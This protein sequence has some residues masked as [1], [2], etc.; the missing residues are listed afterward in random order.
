MNGESCLPQLFDWEEVS[1]KFGCD[2]SLPAFEARTSLTRHPVAV[3]PFNR[4]SKLNPL[5]ISEC[6][7]I[8]NVE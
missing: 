4:S 1:T 6:Q 8:D 2:A 7:M 3:L 5:D